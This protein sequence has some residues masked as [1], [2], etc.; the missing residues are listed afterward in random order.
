[1]TIRKLFSNASLIGLLLGTF[2][3][4]GATPVRGQDRPE[5][6]L[7]RSRTNINV[8]TFGAKGDGVTDDTKAIQAAIS[9]ACRSS[10][11]GGGGSVFFPTPRNFYKVMQ[12]QLPSTLPVF[13]TTGQCMG[14]HLVGGNT[15]K[16]HELPQFPFAPMVAI[17]T[18]AGPHPNDAPVFALSSYVT[19]ENLS[20]AGFN[21]AV[22]LYW[23]INVSFR[24]VCL[25]VPGTTGMTDNTPLK[26]SNSFWIW[27]KGGCLMANGSSKTPIVIF[28]GEK[29]LGGEAPLDGLITMEDITAA[30]G[31]MQYIQRVTQFGTAG[32]FVFRNI[33]IED[34]ATDVLAFSAQNGAKFGAFTSITFDHVNTSDAENPSTAVLS[35]NANTLTISGVYM[36][37]VFTGGGPAG[38]AVAVRE[39]AGKVDNIFITNCGGCVT[40]VVDGHG[41]TAGGVTAQ[42][43]NGFDYFV[44][45]NDAN[46]R[47]RTDTYMN[48]NTDGI[49]FRS[50]S[51][52]NKFASIGI[53]PVDGV[54]FSDGASYGYNAQI[55]QATKGA[56]D[57]G[58]ARTLPPSK[59]T[60][61]ATTGGKLSAGTY[62]YWVRATG[63][64]CKT[65]SAPSMFSAGIK[66]EDGN[67]AVDLTWALPPAGATKIKGY[68]V[69]RN[70]APNFG[71]QPRNAFVPG[72][73]ITSFTD[74]GFVNCCD[75]M[76]PVNSLQSVH[77]FTA[78]S[79][80]VNT[81]SP[82]SNLDVNG[83][84]RFT[85]DLEADSH[86]NQA[87]A[88]SDFGGTI[89]ISSG[90]S[91]SH[92][93]AN[94]FTGANAPICTLTPTSDSTAF[95]AY[96]V[97]YRGN[98]GNWTGF[99]AN[100][101]SA[102]SISF[103][104]RCTGNPN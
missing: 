23:T 8:M 85:D 26:I 2:L 96:W 69:F 95:G 40:D 65:E 89:A 17:E 78:N 37:H 71:N 57:I 34:A 61:K 14:L 39:F 77:R 70:T 66:V 44:N 83:T 102:G 31:G 32:N 42:N 60:G 55:Y 28:S 52:G 76:P 15:S 35:V 36:N 101:H 100:I 47:L 6:P 19:V 43:S 103:N 7:T 3:L 5:P 104:Y 97:S 21:Q 50:T 10:T 62:Y 46:N 56:L 9:E 68:C 88:N 49:P 51:S 25:S 33:T 72:G 63:D 48:P 87:V 90:T 73:S 53:D 38:G 67:N 80:G 54:L 92:A 20:I 13:P 93:F 30:G 24:N 4:I 64:N 22:S 29:P 59:V 84:G 1:M 91:A 82:Q 12:P 81:T 58:F 98:R 99:S 45:V 94:A 79:L 74:T 86:V 27:F 18:T 16:I 41:N 11:E 75:T